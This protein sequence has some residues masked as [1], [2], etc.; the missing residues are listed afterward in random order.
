MTFIARKDATKEEQ[1]AEAAAYAGVP[2]AVIDGIWRT[3]SNRGQHATMVGPDTKWGKA[4]G[5]FQQLDGITKEWS[6]RIGKELD[7]FDFSDG[8]TMVAHQLKENMGM[9][10]GSV[11]NA[12]LAYHGGTNQEN[13]GPK[14]R[15][16]LE[17]VTG[18]STPTD[19]NVPPARPR[20]VGVVD[21]EGKKPHMSAED[22]WTAD[23]AAVGILGDGNGADGPY[24]RTFD[25][26]ADNGELL[27]A[28]QAEH[29]GA[30]AKQTEIDNRT[31]FGDVV[32]AAYQNTL[33]PT[34]R[35]MSR[36]TADAGEYAQDPVW[37]QRQRDNWAKSVEGYRESHEHDFLLN[38]VN[39][40]DFARRKFHLDEQKRTAQI[41]SDDGVRGMGAMFLA[42]AAD[43]TTYITG[44]GAMKTMYATG[45]GAMVLAQQGRTGAALGSAV[46]ENAAGGVAY[47]A[48]LQAFG[49]HRTA[50]DYAMAGLMGIVPA[51]I[52]AP[53]LYRTSVN[54]A[55]RKHLADHT[56]KVLEAE[57]TMMEAVAKDLGEDAT[58]TEIKAEFDRR[59][60][61]ELSREVDAMRGRAQPTDR[62]VN[63]RDPNDPEWI[64]Q[65]EAEDADVEP[66]N[67]TMKWRGDTVK[68]APGGR[69]YRQ[70]LDEAV[71]DTKNPVLQKA[72]AMLRDLADPEV[73]DMPTKLSGNARANVR[74]DGLVTMRS[75]S[76]TFT[77]VHEAVHVATI[78]PIE[79]WQ[80]GSRDFGPQTK[81]G[82]TKLDKLYTELRADW[83]AAAGRKVGKDSPDHVEYAFK[84]MHEFAAQALSSEKFQAYL[85]AK[86]SASGKTMYREFLEA[87]A[88]VLG[89]KVEGTKL[90]EVTAA[91]EQLL[92]A[93]DTI[94]RD[95]TGAAVAYTPEQVK[96]FTKWFGDSKVARG[97][98]PVRLYHGTTGNI[99]AFRPSRK[100]GSMYFASEDTSY[101]NS[102]AGTVDD[103]DFKFQEAGGNV[104]PLYAKI[105]DPMVVDYADYSADTIAEFESSRNDGLMVMDGD[106]IKIAVV[107]DPA[108]FKSAVG[109]NG[110]FDANNPDVAYAPKKAKAVDPI[111]SKYGLDTLPAD[112]PTE[113]AKVKAI[114][115]LYRQAEA[116]AA[117]NPRNDV[118]INNAVVESMTKIGM[119]TPAT[120]LAQSDNPVA[121]WVSA[122][123]LEQTTH[124]HGSSPNAAIA[125]HVLAQEY[126]GRFVNQFDNL[127]AM[128]RNERLGVVKGTW[129]D[130][131]DG[132]IRRDFNRAVAEE[133]EGRLLGYPSK[134]IK[135]IVEAADLAER[136][137][138]LMRKEQIDNKTPGFGALPDTS[139][140]YIPHLL[141]SAK[142]ASMSLD[143][144]RA[145]IAALTDQFKNGIE[146]M[147]DDFA[148]KVARAYVKHAT[149][150]AHG[151]SD[152]PADPLNHG[153]AQYIRD[154]MKASGMDHE[155]IRAMENKLNRGAASH[156][157]RRLK[158][159]TLKE[160]TAADGSTFR[161]MDLF[162]TDMNDLVRGHAR[163]V[164]GEV[165]L[166]RFG[167][168]GSAGLDLIKEA[169]SVG[170]QKLTPDQDKAMKQTF[171]ELLGRPIDLTQ[172]SQALNGLL[173]YTSLTKLGGMG[174]TQV[175]EYSN[176]ALHVGLGHTFDAVSSFP[177]LLSEVRAIAKGGKVE[178]GVLGSMEFRGGGG[179]FG[180]EG[181]YVSHYDTTGREFEAYG[182]STAGPVTRALKKAQYGM[183]I[184]S[185]H[186]PIQ[187]VQQRGAAEQVTLK[188]LRLVKEGQ[189]MDKTLA[190]MGFTQEVADEL[191]NH[192]DTAVE[193]NGGRV[194][195]FDITK[196]PADL[197]EKF[198][199]GVRRGVYQI[200]QG[201]FI[202]E[203]G[204]WNHSQ[205]GRL[206]TQ[207][208][209]YPLTAM[210]KQLG[211]TVSVHGGGA[212]GAAVAA[213]MII[214][215]AGMVL[216]VYAA[217]VAFN[218]ATREDKDEYIDRMMS[219]EAVLR[220]VMN[221][222]GM[223][224]MLPDVVDGLFAVAGGLGEETGLMEGAEN[225]F[226]GQVSLGT[227]LP[228]VGSIEQLMRAP[229]NV[230]DPHKMLRLLPY[231]NTPMLVPFI[232]ALRGD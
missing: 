24:Q 15:A 219:P 21:G 142:V 154:A 181:Y 165:A 205:L 153:A 48:V 47:E 145:Y 93:R 214:S 223:V 180:L 36:V 100:F 122:A 164:S 227:V 96:G 32:P 17:K 113:R 175:G 18:Q 22:I 69:T 9:Y 123:L 232:E 202:G 44:I 76:S 87:V 124:A 231:S 89:I 92:S 218:A 60:A 129:N 228:A 31:F 90:D 137:F 64:K 85:A 190:D 29:A 74:P 193:W 158:L 230:S 16:Y 10:N 127:Y 162:R 27:V 38:A 229:E 98:V 114:R 70:F 43:P 14:T 204:H 71:A 79:Q 170:P 125:A 103:P 97:G 41:V 7:P 182:Q 156:T 118:A 132:N 80:Q 13:W 177:R 209:N 81:E 8:L 82:L 39:E 104:L 143:Q 168:Q 199:Q 84:N 121:R 3:E 203:R 83:E 49:E 65:V 192:I 42:G 211:R 26:R 53:G 167:V 119:A 6:K 187:A 52:S 62:A 169:L 215:A 75:D 110:E 134:G 196:L 151:L 208:R 58:P 213:G 115:E 191:A 91:L 105:E 152:I 163:R 161:L 77:K 46:A 207:F 216:P 56:K 5:H 78:R 139:R 166:T 111:D 109:N 120:L 66:V 131:T 171:S 224:G 183:G 63:A 221:Y 33:N 149:D 159:D 138:E 37:M 126:A 23:D 140:G 179:E 95:A 146:D 176:M 34:F 147:S 1:I 148:E 210:E 107:K 101:A 35:F 185:F 201:T 116:W 157:K 12:V 189:K 50:E 195:N 222:I 88:R 188:V 106:Q 11:D 172:E 45:R 226:G 173:T 133:I 72:A 30:I 54:A 186:R 19:Y 200:I 194:K 212:R 225:R 59:K 217:R 25:I 28:R 155:E 94:Y 141:D 128:Y 68:D 99:E 67:S 102:F 57:R 206:L 40:A 55:A 112:S 135:Q 184:V 150:R 174:F 86:P 197:Q 130:I 51:G 117:A 136:Q 160:Y 20:T 198:H 2:A 144:R 220:N 108:Q 178:N 73:W 4:K 61:S